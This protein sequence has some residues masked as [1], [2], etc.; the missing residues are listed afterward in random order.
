MAWKPEEEVRR[1]REPG[2]EAGLGRLLGLE[3]P[4]LAGTVYPKGLPARR[5]VEHCATFFG[6]VG[7]SD[8]GQGCRQTRFLMQFT[9]SYRRLRGAPP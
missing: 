7:G 6:T 3:L 1:R 5:W 4:A 2:R 8:T 9:P